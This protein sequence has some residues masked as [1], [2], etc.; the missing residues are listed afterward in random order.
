MMS[1]LLQIFIVGYAFATG[2][3]KGLYR[4]ILRNI[5]NISEV[6][7]NGRPLR[8]ERLISD[9]EQALMNALASMFPRRNV[10]CNFH[11]EHVSNRFYRGIDSLVIK[12]LSWE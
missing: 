10:G 1:F 7:S 11:F 4:E 3:S 2:K 5:L 9:F 12:P 6:I 8:T